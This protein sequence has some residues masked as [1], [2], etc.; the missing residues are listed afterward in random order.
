M[1]K[2]SVSSATQQT[3][4]T[5]TI[6]ILNDILSQPIRGR[7]RRK[8]RAHVKNHSALKKEGKYW[9]VTALIADHTSN[10]EVCFDS[11]VSDIYIER[12]IP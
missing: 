4:N 2:A 12:K 6:S 11:E 3:A 7:V 1:P 9:A 5:E 8:V 10:I